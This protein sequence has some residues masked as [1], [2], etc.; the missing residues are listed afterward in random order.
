MRQYR[1][2]H[3]KFSHHFLNI[4][5]PHVFNKQ[6]EEKMNE[7][8]AIKLC[9]QQRDPRGFDYLVQKYRREAYY[10]AMGFLGNRADAEEA[11]QESFTRAFESLPRLESLTSFYP[12]F[13]RIL[14][15]GCL[16][17]LRRHDNAVAEDK[18]DTQLDDHSPEQQVLADEKTD[19]VWQ[20]LKALKPEFREILTLKHLNDASYEEI[21]QL[22][23]IPRGTVMSRLYHAR[24]AF[25]L[26]HNCADTKET[27]YV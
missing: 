3:L 14:R 24:K 10:H 17:K 16:N 1:V 20:T 25:Q 15:N 13:Y 11:C 2:W 22:L 18:A 12:W 23:D 9:L 5:P 7:Q 4:F 19:Q 6:S 26:Q 8:T 27:P 21:S